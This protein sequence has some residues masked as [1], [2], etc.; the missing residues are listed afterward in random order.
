MRPP[1]VVLAAGIPKELGD[2]FIPKIKRQMNIPLISWLP[3]CYRDNYSDLYAEKLY[4]RLVEELKSDFPDFLSKRA[5]LFLLYIDKGDGS[6]KELIAR[7]DVEALMLPLSI[8]Y[9]DFPTK[10]G[11]PNEKRRTVN[12]L[13]KAAEKTIKYG[14]YIASMI[15]EEI[16]NRDNRTCLL[17]PRKNYGKRIGKVFDFVRE[18]TS[19]SALHRRNTDSIR[20]EFEKRLRRVSTSLDAVKENGRTYFVGH[21]GLTFKSPNKAGSR[22]GLAPGWNNPHHEASCVVRG[23]M[24]F[25]LSYDPKFHYDC[26]LLSGIGRLFPSCHGQKKIPA[27][28]NHVNIA[29]NDNIR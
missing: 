8:Q 24:R 2:K 19:S 26:E 6:E 1:L 15:S 17:L 4:G 12:R 5:T 27:G 14:L 29:P 9:G 23:R 13:A 22:H 16:N 20:E 21:N 18:V 11:S 28:R 25:G 10:P 7:F 3:L